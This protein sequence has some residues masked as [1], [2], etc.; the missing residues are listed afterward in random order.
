LVDT[1]SSLLAGLRRQEVLERA[2]QY[3]R[4]IDKAVGDSIE[5]ATLERRR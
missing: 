3:W 4:S 2:F 5:A 1:V